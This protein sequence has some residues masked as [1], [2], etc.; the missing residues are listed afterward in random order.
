V[1]VRNGETD[2]GAIL[3]EVK[4]AANW[5]ADWPAKL[6]AD[7]DASRALIGVIV[8]ES[9]P[10]GITSFGQVGDVWVSGF[11]DA[12][13]LA[14]VLRMLVL[15]AWRHKVVAVERAGNAE[16]VF[17]YVVTG[18]FSRRFERLTGIAA[19]LLKD[20]DQDRRALERRWKRIELR[21]REILD[22]RD[23]IGD[24]LLDAIGADAELPPAFRTELPAA[25]V[26]DELPITAWRRRIGARISQEPAHPTPAP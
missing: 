13:D 14:L 7:R 24:D 5:G 12:A 16:K 25:D 20:I 6:I 17:N 2:C 21:I 9:L 4:R 19:S 10:A 22:I 3:W 26:E 1:V 23:A 8:S 11:A 15:T 18:N